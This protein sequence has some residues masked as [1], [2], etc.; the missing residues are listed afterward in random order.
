MAAKSLG[1]CN[2]VTCCLADFGLCIRI[3]CTPYCIMYNIF[4]LK[5]GFC[6]V[7]RSQIKVNRNFIA[8]VATTTTTAAD[9]DIATLYTHFDQK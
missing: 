7:K 9:A 3:G 6:M 8:I 2:S 1:D 5:Y 4:Y